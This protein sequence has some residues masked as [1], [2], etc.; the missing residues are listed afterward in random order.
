M[1]LNQHQYIPLLVC[2][3][4]SISI[5]FNYESLSHSFVVI[6][7]VTTRQSRVLND[8]ILNDMFIRR[9]EPMLH[10]IP[11]LGTMDMME[12]FPNDRN[13]YKSYKYIDL[14]TA[15]NYFD[16]LHY[17]TM[18]RSVVPIYRFNVD[19][20]EQL[21]LEWSITESGPGNSEYID[22]IF[23]NTTMYCL[24]SDGYVIKCDKPRGYHRAYVMYTVSCD[25]T[26]IRHMPIIQGI[27][28]STFVTNT[29]ATLF[30]INGNNVFNTNHYVQEM[31]YIVQ[32]RLYFPICS[33][34]AINMPPVLYKYQYKPNSF[35]A[36]QTPYFMPND[37]YLLQYMHNEPLYKYSMS[38]LVWPSL[39]EHELYQPSVHRL[40]EFINY[41][42]FIGINHFYV[43]DNMLNRNKNNFDLI[44]KCLFNNTIQNYSFDI[45]T[46]IPIYYTSI[47]EMHSTRY[48]Q[49]IMIFD[50]IRKFKHQSQWM[51]FQDVDEYIILNNPLYQNITD[52]I[53]SEIDQSVISISIERKLGFP[54]Y[55]D[56]LCC[57]TTFD[58]YFESRLWISPD[59]TQTLGK[60]VYQ[61]PMID[62]G[63]QH[64]LIAVWP[65]YS[66]NRSFKTVL[67]SKSDDIYILHLSDHVTAN[68][69]QI[70]FK[71]YVD[72]H[73]YNKYTSRLINIF[74][75]FKR[76]EYFNTSSKDGTV[77]A[78]TLVGL[79][80]GA[81]ELCP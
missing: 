76:S 67:Y 78:K 42:L 55:S 8:T 15:I 75:A 56:G 32:N 1:Q 19:G 65:Y 31:E 27:L 74:S 26:S 3:V 50:A 40:I 81:I 69:D 36:H 28:N 47:P 33:S 34:M 10:S 18:I 22:V 11:L 72:N 64:R 25:V 57:N 63:T 52:F 7:D 20:Q 73:Q 45:I 71:E 14:F 13:P 58:T 16:N 44:Y 49:F 29:S 77:V 70:L 62:Y 2:F 80:N 4:I 38:F 53:T 59:H 48:Y 30:A 41:H 37:N 21:F 35:K 54:M 66:V 6:N 43:F 17:P 24:F 9:C 61:I 68:S 46:Y 60:V 12:T 5:V 79:N 23:K 39:N 51:S